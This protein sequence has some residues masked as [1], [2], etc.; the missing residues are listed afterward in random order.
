MW[1]R[2]CCSRVVAGVARSRVVAPGTPGHLGTS[3]R[4]RPRSGGLHAEDA[5]P[6]ERRYTAGARSGAGSSRAPWSSDRMVAKPSAPDGV[7]RPPGGDDGPEARPVAEYPQ[8]RQ[9]VDHDRLE[10]L[11]WRQDQ[12]PGESQAALPRRAPPAGALVADADGNRVDPQGGR[13]TPD[14]AF[15]QR[16]GRIPGARPRERRPSNA[17]RRLP[18]GRPAR[19]RPVRP[20][21]RRSS[22]ERVPRPAPDRSRCSVPRNRSW[23]PSR[24][25]PR[26][27]SRA[28]S[29]ACPSRCRRNHAS[30]SARNRCTWGSGSDQPRRPDGGTVTTTP[31]SGRMTTRR[32]RDLGERRRMNG[33][34]PPGSTATEASSVVTTRW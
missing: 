33:I 8:V 26:A 19:P 18:A 5:A 3:R 11:W 1:A 4:R 10:G 34:G 13:M 21:A 7:I 20:R 14:L 27:A 25:P 16:R 23:A 17:D 32:P 2:T 28:R 24:R 22:G 15:D 31:R 30:R 6:T 9:L 29:W 12:P